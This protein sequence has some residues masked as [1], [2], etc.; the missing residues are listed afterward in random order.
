MAQWWNDRDIPLILWILLAVVIILTMVL[1]IPKI[2]GFAASYESMI[3]SAAQQAPPDRPAIQRALVNVSAGEFTAE[4]T[5][6]PHAPASDTWT[7]YDRLISTLIKPP[8]LEE[9]SDGY[10]SLIP[11]GT[12]YIGSQVIRRTLYVEFSEEFFAPHLLG[13]KGYHAMLDQ[14]TITLSRA[15]GIDQVL[16]VSGGSAAGEPIAL[17]R[18]Q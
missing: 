15:A 7:V 5:D 13:D 18:Q 3:T 12:R 1:T 2:L 6:Y 10:V 11:E 4:L 8:V 14:L 17:P 9:L 16:L